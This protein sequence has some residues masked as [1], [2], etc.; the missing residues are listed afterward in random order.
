MEMRGIRLW[1]LV[2]ILGVFLSQGE[3]WGGVMELSSSF[4]YS[5]T[6]YSDLSYS[7]SRRVGLGL[8]YYFW[9][10]SEL[11]I[12]VQDILLR[13][14]IADIGDTSLHDQIFSLQWVQGLAPSEFWIHPYFKVG[15]GQLNRVASGSSSTGEAPLEYGTITGVLGAGIKFKV[16]HELSLK[17]EGATYLINGSITTAQ[18]N[19]AINSGL[20]IYF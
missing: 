3:S 7:W 8:G 9:G 13:T 14:K 18:D 5:R 17:V 2:F 20:S 19:F 1:G 6:N 12:E 4:S 10:E 16:Y 15:I 11:E